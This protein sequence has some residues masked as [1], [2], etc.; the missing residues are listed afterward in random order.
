MLDESKGRW[1]TRK[2]QFFECLL[3]IKKRMISVRKLERLF[4]GR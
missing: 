3:H 2:N 4:Q 1:E